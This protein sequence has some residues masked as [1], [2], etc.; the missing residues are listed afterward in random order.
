[1]EIRVGDTI[2]FN[3]TNIHFKIIDIN[4]N[5]G[6]GQILYQWVEDD[7]EVVEKWYGNLIEVNRLLGRRKVVIINREFIS[8][9]PEK[10]RIIFKF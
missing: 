1:M 5:K 3:E 10:N 4:L 7:G 9:E 6:Y 2:K 8:F